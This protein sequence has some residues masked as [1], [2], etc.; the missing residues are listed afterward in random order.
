MRWPF[1]LAVVLI[2][3]SALANITGSATVIDGDTIKIDGTS[4]RLHGID[5]P[6]SFQTCTTGG[7][8]W[9]CGRYA[10]VAL[11]ELIGASPVRCE[12]HDVDRYG[13]TI[14][15]CSVRG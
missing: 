14:A 4:I 9:P 6:E 2:T 3:T 5:A 11:V 7:T 15:S 13:R 12:A 8:S 1:I 10:T